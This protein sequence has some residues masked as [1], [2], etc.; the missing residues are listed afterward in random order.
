MYDEV[1]GVPD[2]YDG[3]LKLWWCELS[4]CGVGDEVPAVDGEGTYSVRLQSRPGLPPRYVT[5]VG[6]RIAAVGVEE[7]LAGS[8]VF[9]KWGGPEDEE[10]PLLVAL[11]GGG[12]ST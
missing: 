12:R 10:N 2:G 4:T 8:P 1:D 9:S 11:G 5:V 6:G 7:P 3:Q